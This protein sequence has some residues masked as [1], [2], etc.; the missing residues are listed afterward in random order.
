[1]RGLSSAKIIFMDRNE[2]HKFKVLAREDNKSSIGTCLL[3]RDRSHKVLSA[4]PRRAPTQHPRMDVAQFLRHVLVA[5]L[6][7]QGFAHD[8][9]N[10]GDRL[11]RGGVGWG[12]GCDLTNMLRSDIWV[13]DGFNNTDVNL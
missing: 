12:G 2:L 8:A 4:L 1:M 7:D 5:R 6:S 13:T 3:V 11:A 10:L 9:K